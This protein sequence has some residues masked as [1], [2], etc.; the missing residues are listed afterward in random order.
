MGTDH[1]EAARLEAHE[2]LLGSSSAEPPCGF[3]TLGP[4]EVRALTAT[5]PYRERAVEGLLDEFY[6][7]LLDR[8]RLEYFLREDPERLPRLRQLHRH[9]FLTIEEAR[10][11]VPGL[12]DALGGPEMMKQ[13]RYDRELVGAC[14]L[15]LVVGV[16]KL[17]E[18]MRTRADLAAILGAFIKAV[19]LGLSSAVESIAPPSPMAT[20]LAGT[21]SAATDALQR[22][23]EAARSKED[24]VSML[25]H[26]LRNPVQGIAL[27]AHVTLQIASK[28]LE[29]ERDHLAQ[30]ERSCQNLSHLLQDI[31][32]T[33]K[34]ET[35]HMSVAARP[36]VL[37]DL[38]DE[39]L[40]QHLSMI[41]AAG[42]R[43]TR[44][45]EANLPIVRVDPT[46]LSRV[47]AN[48]L[49]NAVRH[50]GS[51]EIRVEA[52]AEPQAV[53]ARIIDYGQGV[54]VSDQERIF[55]KFA[56]GTPSARR[57]TDAIG[58]GL[59]FCKLAMEAMGGQLHL[60]SEPGRTV[61]EFLLPAA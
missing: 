6:T 2:E 32:E 52:S 40:G 15:Y 46:L 21:L 36:V 33:A 17:C 57:P 59:Y 48:L 45:L 31:L 11:D 47:F 18:A 22:E 24:L 43:L 34:L 38:L 41:T 8:T 56:S 61:F 58:L 42:M 55:E 50:S 30:I 4:D 35:G 53:S 51:E 39:V 12:V 10:P 26:D 19:M 14:T 29:E 16:S 1:P 7:Q 3:F 44:A 28:S 9:H 54:P 13:A 49:V 60:T 37:T 27:Q 5:R 25:V 23:R 20:D